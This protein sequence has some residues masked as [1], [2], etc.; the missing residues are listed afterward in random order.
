MTFKKYLLIFGLLG[1]RLVLASEASDLKFIDN[2]YRERNFSQAMTSSER[3]L[4]IYPNSRNKN[5][6]R[7]KLAKLYF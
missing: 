2:L 7:E 3:F 4:T 6:V 5:N 1:S